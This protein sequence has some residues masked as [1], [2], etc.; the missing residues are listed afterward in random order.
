MP[1]IFGCIFYKDLMSWYKII[2]DNRVFRPYLKTSLY[3]RNAGGKRYEMLFCYQ[4]CSYL[5]W[6]KIDVVIKKNSLDSRLK[7]ENL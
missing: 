4:N 6:E 5:L 3:K 1:M 7:A 2:K